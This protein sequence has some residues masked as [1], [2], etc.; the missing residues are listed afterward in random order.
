MWKCDCGCGSVMC[1]CGSVMCECGSV[2]CGC[3]SVMCECGSVIDGRY[4]YSGKEYKSVI[5]V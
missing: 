5:R 3:G 4:M 2:M 1:E